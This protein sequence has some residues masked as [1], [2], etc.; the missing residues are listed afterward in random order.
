MCLDTSR[1]HVAELRRS[2][3]HSYPRRYTV[4]M[5]SITSR[6]LY[7]WGRSR[8]YLLNRT[9]GGHENRSGSFGDE[10]NLFPLPRFSVSPGLILLTVPI[11]PA[12][13]NITKKIQEPSQN[14]RRQNDKKK[15]YTEVCVSVHHMWNW[16]EIPTWCNNL[17]III[18]SS[19]CFGHLYTH[20]QEY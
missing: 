20:L 19:T 16:R 2:T 6:R 4:W 10:I 13:Q 14:S 8:L 11:Q 17:F 3:T 9:P 1:K 5:V 18:N 12:E 15:L 7:P